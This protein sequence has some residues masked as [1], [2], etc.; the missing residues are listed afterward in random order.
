MKIRFSLIAN[1]LIFT[2]TV[3]F[4]QGSQKYTH[5]R[6]GEYTD[7]LKNTPYPYVLPIYGSKV[8]KLGYDIPLPFGVMVNVVR[9][10]QEMT[11]D[12]LSV[13]NDN[14]TYH[15]VSNIVNFTKVDPHVS[16]VNLRPDVWIFPFLNV[17]G[18][19]GRVSSETDVWL[20]QPAD[21][22]FVAHNKGTLAGFGVMLAGGLGPLF[23]SYEYNGT[24]NFTERLFNSTYTSLNGIRI[25]HQFKNHKRP[26]S[27]W[28][29]WT[30]VESM[31]LSKNSRGSVNLND[32]TGISQED[33]QNASGQLD[34]WYNE[35][36]RPEQIL[37]EPIYDKMSSWLNDG[38]DAV[39]YYDFDKKVK[40]QWNMLL[41][42]QYQFN[43]NWMLTFESSFI[44]SRWR[45]VLSGVYRFGIK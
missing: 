10:N 17:S 34:A 11:V 35:L 31:S 19:V 42:T 14:S 29:I 44:G 4:G 25:G 26:Q 37:L 36:P 40:Q 8:Q 15:D 33:K 24:W 2:T 3:T 7:S 20:D 22:K 16:V 18:L 5:D 32:L 13:S 21:L 28:T 6:L 38:E 27:S 39:L 45:T 1:I 43:K 30:G 9:G 12:R 23:I 41:G